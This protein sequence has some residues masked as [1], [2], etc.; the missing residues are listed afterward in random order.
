PTLDERAL[1]ADLHLAVLGREAHRVAHDVV[2]RAPQELGE[3]AQPDGLAADEVD[4]RVARLGLD[5]RVLGDLSYELREVELERFARGFGLAL[6]ARQ[7][8]DF[9]D[10]L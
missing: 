2:D 5:V 9:S 1:E 7:R 3:A 10:E 4:A 6:E 8:E